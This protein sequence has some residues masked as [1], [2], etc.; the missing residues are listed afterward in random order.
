MTPPFKYHHQ[1]NHVLG[2]RLS[3]PDLLGLGE[4]W[5]QFT[6]IMIETRMKITTMA[7]VT[8]IVISTN[9]E[10]SSNIGQEK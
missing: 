2:F 5:I 10:N 9:S 4:P 8:A 7:K 1:N 3:A 6:N